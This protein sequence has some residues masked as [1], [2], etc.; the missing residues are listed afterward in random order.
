MDHR[1]QWPVAWTLPFLL[2][3]PFLLQQS[4]PRLCSSTAT[5]LL[6]DPLR[7]S[8]E[9]AAVLKSTLLTR[10]IIKA[11]A[12][13]NPNSDQ[14]SPVISPRPAHPTSQPHSILPFPPMASMPSC[15][16]SLRSQPHTFPLFSPPEHCCRGRP[17][18]LA[19]LRLHSR[20]RRLTSTKGCGAQLDYGNFLGRAA[21]ALKSRH[22][23]PLAPGC[24]CP[25]TRRSS[26]AVGEPWCPAAGVRRL[27]AV[28][29]VAPDLDVTLKPLKINNDARAF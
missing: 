1:S 17:Y 4:Q 24:Q 27:S 5:P 23:K 16:S 15:P 11:A 2:S 7:T 22:R 8:T 26:C 10:G 29:F 18:P 20:H 13:Q 25:A 12:T 14:S 6:F 3:T 19:H 28:L 9:A 21:G